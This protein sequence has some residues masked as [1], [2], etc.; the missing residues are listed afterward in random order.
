ML[1]S[2]I[3]WS[4]QPSTY[5]RYNFW[6]KIPEKNRNIWKDSKWRERPRKSERDMK[7][8][9][10]G[11]GKYDYKLY[12]QEWNCQKSNKNNTAK[13]TWFFASRLKYIY[14]LIFKFLLINKGKFSRDKSKQSLSWWCSTHNE[15]SVII[16]LFVP[17]LC[18]NMLKSS[19][20]LYDVCYGLYILHK[21]WH[22]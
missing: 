7:S 20:I 12:I 14:L 1:F 10:E 17:Q 18:R 13:D 4:F 3:A 16:L 11:V 6:N 19:Q 5:S 22:Y 15:P 8:K 2:A 21:E 9:W